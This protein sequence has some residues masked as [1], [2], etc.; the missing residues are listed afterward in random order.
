[1]NKLRNE[2][3]P[4]LLQHKDNPVHWEAWN[5]DSINRSTVENKPIIVSI[6][7]AA[8]HWCHVMEHESFE[9]LE[10][11]DL[12]NKYFINIK[13]DREE[14][15]DLDMIYMDAIQKMGLRGGWP[16]NIFL[17]PNQKPFYGGT[18]YSKVNWLL[19][20]KS[21]SKAFVINRK[22]LEK[23]ADGFCESIN[24]VSMTFQKFSFSSN[25]NYEEK[26]Y[27]SIKQS[28][29]PIFGGIN[30]AP[31][32]PLPNLIDFLIN[33]PDIKYLKLG[34]NELY[35]VQL[36]KMAQGGIYDQ[37]EG[38][39]SRYS[40]DS[41][42]F[43]P[44]F[45]KM[46]YDNVQLI[47]TY[48]KAFSKTNF[49]LY[50]EVVCNTINF[51]NEQLKG[52]NGLYFSSIDADSEGVEGKYYTW[53]Y[54]ELIFLLPKNKN[55]DFHNHFSI[56]PQGNWE[57]NKNILFKNSSVSN[58]NFF[59]QLQIL[60]K[61]KA[62]RIRPNIDNKQ[63]L[64]WN[65]ML[66][67]SLLQAHTDFQ[68]DLYFT[69]AELL[70]KKIEYYFIINDSYL[71]QVKFSG[72]PINAF[73]DDMSLLT[74]AYIDF[75]CISG[76][77]H[78]LT[79]AKN[80]LVYILLNFQS[81][82]SNSIFYNYYSKKSEKLIVEKYDIHDSVMPSSNSILCECLMKIGFLKQTPKYTLIGKNMINHIM[83]SAINNP[84]YYSNWLRIFY[85]YFE[86]PKAIVKF[87]S[88]FI[89]INLLNKTNFPI[90][91]SMMEFIP[92]NGDS[93]KYNFY[94]CIGETCYVPTNTIIE[95]QNQMKKII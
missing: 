34:V 49:Y 66:V 77:N 27:Q 15:P 60:K 37:I 17:L 33:L 76:D 61:E 12:M 31:K 75:Y 74:K 68:N 84:L 9:D 56:L 14:R 91:N 23:S 50:K 8:C 28:M 86:Y 95:L 30:K 13:I 70:I 20:L 71:H 72:S 46:L 82:K 7:Y 22:E 1:M 87:K 64:S 83:E 67:S 62:Y 94:L 92:L 45:E 16:L 44:H 69:S 10:V 21:I 3:S 42:W 65:S 63:I 79:K 43:C 36:Q 25:L 35:N 24:D 48:S 29:D 55:K 18:Y 78:Y 39:F 54:E 41:E 73:L 38:G 88:T 5:S 80:C 40:V 2:V 51:L 57:N 6:G 26:I 89:K 32:F 53:T 85:D 58:Q 90:D 59:D 4:Y 19:L 47:K 81:K 52:D 93:Y 11:A